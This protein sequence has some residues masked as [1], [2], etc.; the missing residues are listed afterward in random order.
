MAGIVGLT[1]TGKQI[2]LFVAELTD[3]RMARRVLRFITTFSREAGKLHRSVA[4]NHMLLTVLQRHFL[5]EAAA[6]FEGLTPHQQNLID[7]YV[8]ELTRPN[9]VPSTKTQVA[10]RRKAAAA[11]APTASASTA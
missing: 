6:R 7:Q 10:L 1:E 8:R 3:K 2:D 4:D 11:S 5:C 9:F